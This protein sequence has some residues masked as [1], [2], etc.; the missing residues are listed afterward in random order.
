[1]DYELFKTKTDIL[2]LRIESKCLFFTRYDSSPIIGDGYNGSKQTLSF[3]EIFPSDKEDLVIN[4]TVKNGWIT[5]TS[6]SEVED[7]GKLIFD[8]SF[9]RDFFD[10]KYIAG[11]GNVKTYLPSKEETDLEK[12]LY[13]SHKELICAEKLMFNAG[14][15]A[16]KIFMFVNG[17]VNN[18][19]QI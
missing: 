8:I 13:D 4:L 7:F 6:N 19:E 17:K 5:L 18:S 12:W 11:T 1:M 9:V 3:S 15:V 2:I 10:E 14:E 16:R